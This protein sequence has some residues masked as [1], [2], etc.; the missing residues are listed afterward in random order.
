MAAIKIG[1]YVKIKPPKFPAVIGQGPA[2]TSMKMKINQKL[3]EIKYGQLFKVSS[4]CDVVKMDSKPYPLIDK[5]IVENNKLIFTK[6]NK[7]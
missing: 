6:I 3:Y 4:K 7:E 2:P 1:D 5:K